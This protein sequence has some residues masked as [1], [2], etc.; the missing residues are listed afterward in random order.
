MSSRFDFLF[1]WEILDYEA[2]S[3]DLEES[4]K[5][6]SGIV[7]VFSLLLLDASGCLDSSRS[8]GEKDIVTHVS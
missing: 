2:F 4:K 7:I 1:K 3:Q 5:K 6:K 8:L